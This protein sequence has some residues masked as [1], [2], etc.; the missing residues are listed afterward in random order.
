MGQMTHKA[1]LFIHKTEVMHSLHTILHLFLNMLESFENM[2][3]L[4]G[5]D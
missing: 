4:I 1:F 5:M 3:Q 2:Q